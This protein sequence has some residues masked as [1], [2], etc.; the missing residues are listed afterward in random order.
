MKRTLALV[1]MAAMLCSNC[2]ARGPALR[3]DRP[4]ASPTPLQLMRG[5]AESRAGGPVG[6]GSTSQDADVWRRYA[7]QL[8]IGSIVRV[9]TTDGERLTAVLMATDEAG[10]TVMPKTRIPEPARPVAFDRLVQLEL[11][12]DGSNLAKAAAVGGAVGAGVFVG[13]LML[14]FA[15]VD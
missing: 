1:V 6:S 5:Q 10:I 13:L 9:R 3:V 12:R 7:A 15:N 8:P 14:L 2:A 11:A 4:L